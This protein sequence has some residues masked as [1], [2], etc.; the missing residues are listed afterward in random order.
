MYTVKLTERYL[1]ISYGDVKVRISGSRV[2][3]Q[4]IEEM[5]TR[6]KFYPLVKGVAAIIEKS[7]KK[8]SIMIE[9]KVEEWWYEGLHF[10][11]DVPKEPLSGDPDTFGRTG[12]CWNR[13]KTRTS[14][15][16]D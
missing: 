13:N 3:L 11:T 8:P 14:R 6:Y 2:K 16:Y 10:H 4:K 15:G 9:T 12:F 1:Y 5:S 7:A